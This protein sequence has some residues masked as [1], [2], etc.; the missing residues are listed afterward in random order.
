MKGSKHSTIKA[1]STRGTSQGEHD[2]VSLSIIP[3]VLCIM[4]T[5]L[6]SRPEAKAK[7]EE[8]VAAARFALGLT[9]KR[10]RPGLPTTSDAQLT[11][12]RMMSNVVAMSANENGEV[13]IEVEFLQEGKRLALAARE[14]AKKK[15]DLRSAALV[16]A[17]LK[18]NQPFGNPGIPD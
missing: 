10:G 12:A 14:A 18:P 4:A 3:E 17:M 6:D 15:G 7:M 8:A 13:S 5:K 9:P 16:D 1:T 11:L 2:L